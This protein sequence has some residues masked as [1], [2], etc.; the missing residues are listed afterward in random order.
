MRKPN[1]SVVVGAALAG[2]TLALPAQPSSAQSPGHVSTVSTGH[3]SN[4]HESNAATSTYYLRAEVIPAQYLSVGDALT[5][6]ANG[7]KYGDALNANGIN[8]NWTTG[9]YTI[10]FAVLVFSSHTETGK[11]TFKVVSPSDHAVYQYSYG[12]EQLPKGTDWFS[13]EAKANYSAP[14]LYFAEWFL[15]SNMDGW[16]PLNFSS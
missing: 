13:V 7:T 14:G 10:D 8:N 11:V 16:A 4:G 3:V 15:G 12:T 9:S 6:G 2:L 5:G 1:R